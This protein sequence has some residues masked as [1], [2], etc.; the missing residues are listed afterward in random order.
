MVPPLVISLPKK[1]Q[2]KEHSFAFSEDDS[3]R[4][5]ESVVKE[6][7]FDNDFDQNIEAAHEFSENDDGH[8]K[9]EYEAESDFPDE[10][11]DEILNDFSDCDT[12]LIDVGG[13]AGKD[14]SLQMQS[15]LYMLEKSK[16]KQVSKNGKLTAT[17]QKTQRKDKGVS[18]QTQPTWPINH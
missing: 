9:A 6:D 15:S 2:V 5:S 4:F 16:K 3:D 11:G 18:T 14:S 1:N 17:R 10:D 8:M 7:Y 12:D 13:S